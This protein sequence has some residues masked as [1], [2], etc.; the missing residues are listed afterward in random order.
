MQGQNGSLERVCGNTDKIG[1]QYGI[2]KMF[3]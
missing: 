3:E 1:K 2:R